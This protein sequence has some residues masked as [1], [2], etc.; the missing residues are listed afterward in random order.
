M[1]RYLPLAITLVIGF[2]FLSAVYI[3][4]N[5]GGEES[6]VQ[7]FNAQ[8]SYQDVLNQVKLGPRTPGSQ[9]HAAAG[10]YIQA[11][12][13]NAGWDVEIQQLEFNQ[14]VVKNIVARRGSGSPLILLGA[15]YDSRLAADRDPDPDK[16]SQPVPGANDG[17]SGVAV[18]LELSRIIPADIQG[19][20]WMVFFDLEDQ[21]NLPGYDWILGSRAFAGS[22]EL[23]PEAVVILDMIGDADLNVYLEKNSTDVLRREIWAAAEKL[24]FEEYLI[25]QEKYSILDDHTPFLEL[26]IPAADLIDFD[27]PHY[28]TTQDTADKVAPESLKIIGDTIIEWLT[29]IIT[30]GKN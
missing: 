19:Q 17:A 21:G 30:V 27:Y 13:V 8:R 24:S 14:H 25:P 18:L 4:N 3:L 9:A 22:L 16:R 12:L 29:P 10:E 7:E 23:T 20:I 15:H 5:A 2:V 1:K 28:H 6:A 11:E 26:G